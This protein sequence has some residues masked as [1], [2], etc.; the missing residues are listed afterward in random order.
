M[1]SDQLKGNWKQLMGD[2]KKQWGKLTDDDLKQVEGRKDKLVG[3]I[4]ER[5]GSSREEAEKQAD[6]W[7]GKHG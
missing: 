7:L 3:K 6:D 1:N 4:Q 2:A 5:Y